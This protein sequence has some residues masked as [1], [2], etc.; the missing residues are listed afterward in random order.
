MR[1]E[2]YTVVRVSASDVERD[3]GSVVRRIEAQFPPAA[4]EEQERLDDE[5]T[6]LRRDNIAS[7]TPDP[8][9]TRTPAQQAVRAVSYRYA[10]TA[11]ARSFR[12]A[13]KPMPDCCRHCRT[14]QHVKFACRCG[15]VALR[16]RYRCADCDVAQDAAG[17]G[18]RAYTGQ[19]PGHAR[20]GKKI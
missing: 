17:P 11:C 5:A 12:S 4:R 13:E 1:A 15:A 2:R 20:R 14:S 10:C 3:V 16:G 6:M 7:Q 18:A 8:A 9:F 19:A